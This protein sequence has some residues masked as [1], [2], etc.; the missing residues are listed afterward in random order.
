MVVVIIT[1]KPD[2]S[3]KIAEA[4]AE[5]NTLKKYTNEENVT[6]YEFMRNGKKH[7]V[8]CA[9]GHL[10]NLSPVSKGW[11]YPVFDAEW[12]P[13]FEVN[14]DAKFSK[15]YFDVVKEMIGNG[16]EYI[17]AT[18]Y[19]TEGSV[20]GFNIL[21]FLAGLKDAYRMKFSTLTKDE[22]I[23]AYNNMSKHLDFNQ[24]EA[25]LTR[26]QLD[27]LWGINL[28][29]ALT[30]ALKNYN[31]KGFSILSSGR[32]QS[33]TLAMLV[34]RELEI[35]NFKPKPFWELELHVKIDGI[36]AV[37]NYEKGRIWNKDDADK[38]LQACKGKDAIVKDI[39]KKRY[40]QAPPVPFN[41]TDLQAEAYQQF[42]FSPQQT[43]SIAESLYQQG[44]ISYP[45]SSSQKLPPSINYEKI[46]KALASL[47]Q[48]KKFAEEL[49]KKEKLVPVEGKKDDPAHPA[50]YSTHEIPD[51]SKLTPQERK[52]YDLITRRT[53]AVFA[54]E[55]IRETNTVSLDVNGHIFLLVGKRT[56]E[57]G[58]TKI[59]E[60]YLKR[61]ELILPELKIGQTVK[62]IKLEELAKET[63]PPA[64]YSQGSIIKEMESRNLGTRATRS[65][66]LQT[67]YD[68]GYISGKSIQVT[69]LG[70]AV[71][72]ALKEY[73]PR[74]VSEELT[75]KFEEEMELVYNGKKK[76][77]DVINEARKTLKEILEEFKLN[78]KSI[79][80]KL[81]EALEVTREEER[82]IG[83]CLNCKT[84]YLRIFFSP[85]TKKR[86]VGC[87]NYFNCG[88]CGFSIEA[89]KC[90]CEICGREKRKCKHTWK[91]KKWLPSCKTSFPLPASGQIK[92]LE[93]SCEYCGWPLIQ[94]WRKGSR[95]FKMCLLP[96]CAS[97]DN[98]KS[99]K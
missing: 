81:A 84:G 6:Y 83:T 38:I 85:V 62:V 5:K 29:R 71:T 17:V 89:C 41:T 49:L 51:L 56:L 39:K 97:K 26:H 34:E 76:R 40:K 82:T 15:K 91:E 59:Y 33:P 43:M 98:W 88:N 16:S 30:L 48:Y 12:K 99:K 1:E 94:V 50:V 46:L 47:P 90:E 2:A 67:L 19:D 31:G 52:I 72:K 96:N 66:I 95:P 44:F 79:G 7:I 68:R 21:R 54:D 25:G 3:R 45:R 75:R 55:A 27:W 28:T 93:K 73:C 70:E 37:A 63:Q 58:W 64:R 78:E 4:L 42:K 10:F 61:E 60:P 77:E 69:K 65:E 20:I 18:D 87:T 36:E 32:V 24:I 80:K 53:L 14:R 86:W 9:V 57:P 74:I 13:S 22:L 92:S 11:I 35:R 8:V 23:E